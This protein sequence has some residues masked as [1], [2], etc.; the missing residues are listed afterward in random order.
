MFRF[1][2]LLEALSMSGGVA[3]T[4]DAGAIE[5]LGLHPK[6]VLSDARNLKVT[7]PQD[8]ALAELI[9]KNRR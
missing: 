9:L 4:D 3:M 5:A 6:L 7:Y 1:K 2:L 8:L